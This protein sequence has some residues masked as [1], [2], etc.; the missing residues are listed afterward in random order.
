MPSYIFRFSLFFVVILIIGLGLLSKI[1]D[2]YSVDIKSNGRWEYDSNNKDLQKFY[3]SSLMKR[4]FI[5]TTVTIGGEDFLF[6]IDTGSSHSFITSRLNKYIDHAS[7]KKGDFFSYNVYVFNIF[8]MPMVKLKNEI[9]IGPFIGKDVMWYLFDGEEEISKYFDG[10]IGRDILINF[11]LFLDYSSNQVK[12]YLNNTDTLNEEILENAEVLNLT[13]DSVIDLICNNKNK[14]A[15]IDTG[16]NG[17]I[18]KYDIGFSPLFLNEK[19]IKI[20]SSLPK[21][22]T[23]EVFELNDAQVEIGNYIGTTKILRNVSLK[24]LFIRRDVLFIGT[25]FLSYF[26]WVFDFKKGKVYVRQAKE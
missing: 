14:K 17:Y 6:L 4:D 10:V 16:N 26:D 23:Q 20:E 22:K 5:K 25:A 24:N 13:N 19:Y 2:F 12:L 7:R 8:H 11:L 15:F 9:R 18:K 21:G 1:N 3:V